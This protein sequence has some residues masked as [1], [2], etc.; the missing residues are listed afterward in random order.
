LVEKIVTLRIW[1]RWG[2]LVFERENFADNAPDLGWN[3]AFRQKKAAP[4]VYAWWAKVLLIDGTV[5][6]QEGEVTLVR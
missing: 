5:V 4:G 1:N 6:D 3:G 2:E